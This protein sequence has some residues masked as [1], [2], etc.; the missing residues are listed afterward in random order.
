M[1]FLDFSTVENLGWKSLCGAGL[2]CHAHWRM[3]NNMPGLHPPGLHPL[4]Y[5]Q[6][7]KMSPDTAK[8]PPKGDHLLR[9][10]G[11][12]PSLPFLTTA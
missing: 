12:E 1:E 10:P 11:V 2:G 3:L 4:P 9:S 7:P 5:R 8:G 6:Q